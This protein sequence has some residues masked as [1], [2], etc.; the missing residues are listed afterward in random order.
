MYKMIKPE[1][2]SLIRVNRGMYYHH[3]VYADDNHVIHF[4]SLRPGHEMDPEEAS[5]VESTL[6]VFLKG[7]EVETRVY[8]EEELKTVRSPQEVVSYAYSKLGMKGY[9]VLTYNCEHFANECA[10]GTPKSDQV[11]QVVDFLSGLFAKK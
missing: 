8:T 1:F 11:N 4:A 9:N 5:V 6:D 3:G 10:F 2:G 7:G